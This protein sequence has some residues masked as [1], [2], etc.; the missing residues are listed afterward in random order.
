MSYIGNTAQNQAYAPQIA[1][2][3]GN[4]STTAFTLPLPV[5]T[6]AQI[7][8][9]VENVVQNPTY[10]YTVSGNTITFTSAPPANATLPNNIW[11]Q[12][13]S[14]ITQVIQPGQGTVNSTQLGL[15]STIPAPSG[16]TITVPTLAG[17]MALTNQ[18]VGQGQ[19]T[20]AYTGSRAL[21]TTYTNSTSNTIVVYASISNSV[22]SPITLCS[23]S[24]ISI[25]GSASPT[26]GTYYSVVLV[27]PPGATYVVNMNG[28]P[29]LQQW[30]E[31]R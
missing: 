13:T 9:A 27:V 11:V 12:Y 16:N 29:T 8:V 25:Q 24:G 22:S 5:A 4:G 23:I 30:V 7:I 21:G 15:I 19:T 3:S 28:T 10:A 1:Y 17:T 2:F 14:P 6:A 20:A 26:A 31:T 18:V